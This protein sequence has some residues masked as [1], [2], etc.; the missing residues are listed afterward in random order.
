MARAVAVVL[1][2]LLGVVALAR[3]GDEAAGREAS[4][5]GLAG[6][7]V[8]TTEVPMPAPLAFDP[9]VPRA[10]RPELGA[11][12]VLVVRDEA[13]G[14]ELDAMF[15][16][17]LVGHFGRADMVVAS[18]YRAGDANRYDATIYVG[19]R[20]DAP[21]PEAFLDDVVR[22]TRPVVWLGAN[23]W[24]LLDRPGAASFG[25]RWGGYDAAAAGATEVVY[26]D[27]SLT[28]APSPGEA[29]ARVGL[30]D[31]GRAEVLALARTSGAADLAWAV[32]SGSLTWLAEVPFARADEGDRY[33]VYA[34]VLA[35]LLAPT[36]P[37]RH[38]A[39]V[40]L[41]DIGPETDPVA[42][43]KL[44]DAL[45][46]RNVAFSLAVYPRFEDP[47][48]HY[49]DTRPKSVRLAERPALVAVLRSAVARGG[50]LVMHGVTHQY[51]AQANPYD[52]VSA[53]DFEFFVARID[54]HDDVRLVGPVPE[55]A[56]TW[57]RDRIT[58]GLDDFRAAGL[59]RPAYFE[60]PHYAASPDAYR[61]A[62][63][64]FAA[65]FERTLY[66]EGALGGAHD[67]PVRGD[68]FV[69]YLVRDVYG[70]L[71]VPET[72]G[73]VTDLPWNGRP[74]RTPDQIVADAARQRVVRDNVATFFFHPHMPLEALTSIVD[75]MSA[76]GYRWIAPA[77]LLGGVS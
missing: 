17:N 37:E 23:L 10:R 59:P 76:L 72:L 48:G 53:A 8:A 49:V 40:R 64:L 21:L 6:A 11:A 66:V 31:G 4:V 35:G 3:R 41:E 52:G 15:A 71:V 34:D 24:K 51:G 57:V 32:R 60:F 61:S 30:V 38:R 18:A 25:L 67:S 65:R 12:R 45:V 42:L 62:D 16:A 5:P 2:L 77:D 46:A 13:P 43:G 1:A 68:L 19:S 63:A 26:R 47:L 20:Y 50:T 75:R 9:A 33:L 44:V 39:M 55:D 29:L 56:G 69:P 74:P 14:A 54:E 73:F 28:R 22:A 7:S 70:G 27:V 36:A 58:S